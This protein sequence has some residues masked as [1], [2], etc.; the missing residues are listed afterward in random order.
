LSQ[1]LQKPD[2]VGALRKISEMRR[3]SDARQLAANVLEAHASWQKRQDLIARLR[4]LPS[5]KPT[6]SADDQKRLY[7][8]ATGK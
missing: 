8:E 2:L 1:E 5:N 7:R 6:L 3:A 4:A